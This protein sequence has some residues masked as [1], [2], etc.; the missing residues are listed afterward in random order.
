MYQKVSIYTHCIA[1]CSIGKYYHW[2]LESTVGGS[3]HRVLIS[4]HWMIIENSPITALLAKKAEIEQCTVP[5]TSNYT[6][7]TMKLCLQ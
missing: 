1:L 5:P 3:I 7:V 6:A 4:Y 2:Q